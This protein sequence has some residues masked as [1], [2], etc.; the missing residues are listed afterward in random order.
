MS[1]IEIDIRSMELV[2]TRV[3]LPHPKDAE[4]AKYYYNK[5]IEVL[6][7]HKAMALQIET[8]F[9]PRLRKLMK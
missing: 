7:H 4:E 5:Y 2:K 9:L 1:T 6:E 8:I 3:V